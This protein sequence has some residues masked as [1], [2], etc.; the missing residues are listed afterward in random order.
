MNGSLVLDDFF[1]QFQAAFEAG[2]ANLHAKEQEKANVA[3]V[4]RFFQAME[5]RDE[6]AAQA[7]F[8]PRLPSSVA[9]PA[10]PAFLINSRRPGAGER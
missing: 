7:A 2:D 5:T 4:Q 10:A 3:L 9:A 1:T 6:P 8:M